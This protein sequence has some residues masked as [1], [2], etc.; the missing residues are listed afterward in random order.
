MPLTAT[1][2]GR[3]PVVTVPSSTGA[4]GVAT[5]NT[6]NVRLLGATTQARVPLTATLQGSA[7]V[8]TEPLAAVGKAGTGAVVPY[9]GAFTPRVP[10]GSTTGRRV[11]VPLR[12]RTRRAPFTSRSWVG[13]LVPMPTLPPLVTTNWSVRAPLPDR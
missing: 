6:C 13:P 11:S 3:P 4:L 5:S 1:L 7:A 12:P 2:M 10:S 9:T 8:P